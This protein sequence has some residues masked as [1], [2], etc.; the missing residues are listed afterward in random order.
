MW[1]GRGDESAQG[2]RRTRRTIW[3]SIGIALISMVVAGCGSAPDTNIPATPNGTATASATATQAT[4]TGTGGQ[5]PHLGDA[6]TAFT[7][8]YGQPVT[9]GLTSGQFNYLSSSS[10]DHPFLLVYTAGFFG[11]TPATDTVQV[12]YRSDADNLGSL[13]HAEAAC[14]AFL[15]SNAIMGK[16]V[17]AI[18]STSGKVSA[19]DILYTSATL[20]H[21]FPAADFQDANQG[22]AQPGSFDVQYLYMTENDPSIIA[23]CSLELG[24]QQ[25]QG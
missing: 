19:L 18:D 14:A 13:S 22:Q 21:T 23:D 8:H 10:A 15:P 4:S 20:A 12:E 9:A 11:E 2:A 24:T 5:Q 7:V 17:R 6:I 16:S 3:M 1:Y 25:T